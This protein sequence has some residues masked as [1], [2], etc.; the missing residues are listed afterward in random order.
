MINLK[1]AILTSVLSRLNNGYTVFLIIQLLIAL[2]IVASAITILLYFN[3]I[4]NNYVLKVV[5]MYSV[6]T[7]EQ[8][9]AYYDRCK[10]YK[11]SFI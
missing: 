3:I 8:I 9:K 6:I 7:I 5:R 4:Y 11:K 10:K 1:S 2:L